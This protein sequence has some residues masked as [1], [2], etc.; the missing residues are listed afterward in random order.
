MVQGIVSGGKDG[1]T[2]AVHVVP[3]SAR[4]EIVG[5]HGRALRIRVNAPPV[6]GAANAVLLATVAA[7]LGLPKRQVE[8]VSGHTSRRKVLRVLGLSEAEVR[9]SL[10]CLLAHDN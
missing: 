1:V 6:G 7:A 9:R 2:L 3:R 4:N 10:E 5:L 8:I